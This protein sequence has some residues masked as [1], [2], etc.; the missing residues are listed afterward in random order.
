ME[1]RGSPQK[2]ISI[3][4]KTPN[5]Q[6]EDQTISGV[7]VSWTVKDLKTHLSTVYPT[8]PAVNE[9]RLIYSGK[10]LPDHLHLRDLSRQTDSKLTLHLVCALKSPAQH[11]VAAKG[12]ESEMPHSPPSGAVSADPPQSQSQA[13]PELRQRRPPAPPT[14]TPTWPNAQMYGAPTVTQPSFPTYSLYSPQQLLWL[15]HVYARQYYMQYQAALAAASTGPLHQP[16]TTMAQYPPVPAPHPVPVPAP[17]ANQNPI[18]NLPANQNPAQ[19]AAFIDPGAAN[20]NMRMNAQGGPVMEDEEDV[21]RDWLDRFY[22]ASQMGVLLMIVYFNS[23]LS[24]FLLVMGMMFFM[25][26]HTLGWFP[27]RRRVVQVQPPNPPQAP[28]NNNLDPAA[29]EA[30]RPAEDGAEENSEPGPMTAV[31][32]PPHRVS[33]M[34]TAWVFLKTF[35][36]SLIP[37]VP[38]GVAN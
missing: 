14:E 11:A 1:A 20:Q 9:Q 26:M 4:V 5:L 3:V 6:Q 7:S 37:E 31:L 12:K 27:F 15:Q 25:Y 8:K 2:T 34:W 32:V 18:D 30:D 10:L 21:E 36:S 23:N 38:Q 28:E 19:D 17:L 13:A 16:T 24:R 35:L 29:E 33:V 22:S